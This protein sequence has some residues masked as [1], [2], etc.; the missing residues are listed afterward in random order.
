MNNYHN[1]VV[2]ALEKHLPTH[3]EMALTSTTKT[4]C[5]S[6]METNNYQYTE[7]NSNHTLG[8]SR[9]NFQVKVW[10]H[11]IKDLVYYA[12]LADKEL[13]ELGFK[14]TSSGELYDNNSTMIQ[15]ILNYECLAIEEFTEVN[16]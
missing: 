13:R 3:Y 7:S 2:N 16:E 6:Y 11:D 9:I 14:R 10:G 4:P 8:Y 12:Q 5:Y 15:K 1:L